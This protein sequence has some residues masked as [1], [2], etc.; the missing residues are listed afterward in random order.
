MQAAADAVDLENSPE[1]EEEKQ[2][3]RLQDGIGVPHIV[4]D[5]ADTSK[6]A[7]IRTVET[8][9]LPSTEEVT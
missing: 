7:F 8:G 5:C 3:K 6:T 1:T 4:I 2:E 9:K